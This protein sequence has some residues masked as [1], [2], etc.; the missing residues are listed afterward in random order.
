MKEGNDSVSI[1]LIEG[2]IQGR[3]SVYRKRETMLYQTENRRRGV[4][5]GGERNREAGLVTGGATAPVTMG[6]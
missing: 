1:Q 6:R 4:N 5:G 3:A 2:R